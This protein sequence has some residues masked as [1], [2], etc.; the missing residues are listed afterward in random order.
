ME[1]SRKKIFIGGLPANITETQLKEQFAHYGTVRCL[2]YFVT[3]DSRC[4]HGSHT[5]GVCI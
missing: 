5:E 2:L 4:L 1:N 3:F